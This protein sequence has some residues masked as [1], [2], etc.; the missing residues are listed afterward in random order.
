MFNEN[1]ISRLVTGGNIPS[2]GNLL[3]MEPDSAEQ[4]EPMPASV[5]V[6]SVDKGST[7][8][9]GEG[10]KNNGW[11][12]FQM[13]DNGYYKGRAA[14]FANAS[15]LKAYARAGSHKEGLVVGDN[16]IG[17]F[18]ANTAGKVPYVAVPRDLL[19]M[20]YGDA[21]NA[22]GKRVEV[23]APNGMRETIEI[24][25]IAPRVENRANNAV[26][27]FNPAALQKLKLKGD[28]TGVSYRF[29]D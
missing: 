19:A 7:P 18:G 27:E 20:R 17:A 1:A 23:I 5:A 4:D 11:G 8:G 21:R 15:D 3:G 14:V 13:D 29:L 25:D 6:S 9:L 22:R 28:T 16:G 2:L 12:D 26:I 10:K 24:G